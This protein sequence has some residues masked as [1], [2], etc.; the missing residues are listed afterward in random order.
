M[1]STTPTTVDPGLHR[2]RTRRRG[3]DPLNHPAAR[4]A[5]YKHGGASGKGSGKNRAKRPW[6]SVQIGSGK[7]KPEEL[8][9]FSRQ[10]SSFLRAGIGVL[11]ALQVIAEE[12]KRPMARALDDM[13]YALR[14]GASFATAVARHTDVF[15]PYYISMVRSAELTG[16][17]D[18][19]LDQLAHYVERDLE[20]RRKV[21]SALTYPSV[22]AVMAVVTVVVL[23]AFVLPQFKKFFGELDSKLPPI[24]RALLAMTD[25][26]SNW[27]PAL[28]GGGACTIATIMLVAKT[29]RGRYRR[30]RFVLRL[31]SVGGLVRFV[32]VERF[33]RIMAALVQAGVALPDALTVAIDST[34]NRV[35]QRGLARAREEMIRGQGLARPIADTGLFPAAANQMIKVGEST[36]TLDEQLG[37]AAS[38]YEGELNYRMKRFTDLFEPAVIVAMGVVVGFVALALVTA[39]YGIFRQANVR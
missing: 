33:C 36:G 26:L 12:A 18:D 22:V 20:A 8:M 7:V 15:P 4:A 38:F 37:S 31:P 14:S 34:S 2:A 13:S 10:C 23:S 35:Y 5:A 1:S 17:L 30:D 28:L 39:M 24:T 29:E 11:D 32:I 25:F 9:N 21:K 6:Y 27:W 16:R 3:K 19:V